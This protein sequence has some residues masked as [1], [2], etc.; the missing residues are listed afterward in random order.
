VQQQA[1]LGGAGVT[2][3]AVSRNE[4]HRSCL[5]EVEADREPDAP[6]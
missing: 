3:Q 5:A 6:R 4:G 2:H 1:Q